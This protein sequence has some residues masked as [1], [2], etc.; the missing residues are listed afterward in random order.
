[1]RELVEE[2]LLHMQY[3]SGKVLQC[4]A[5]C[6]QAPT[7]ATAHR[8]AE[9]D[10]VE[11]DVAEVCHDAEVAA[12]RQAAAARGTGAA[13]CRHLHS[14][15]LSDTCM[16]WVA[17]SQTVTGLF[18]PLLGRYVRCHDRNQPGHSSTDRGRALHLSLP[19]TILVV[20]V[21]SQNKLSRKLFQHCL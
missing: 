14:I 7:H 15:T 12:Q 3:D 4:G 10:F 17:L 9:R 18:P 20:R 11:A 5:V 8:D 6:P 19:S 2:A 21:T 16:T 1:M 13:D